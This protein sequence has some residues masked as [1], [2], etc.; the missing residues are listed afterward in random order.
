MAIKISKKRG[1][2]KEVLNDKKMITEDAKSFRLQFP[3]TLDE[4]YRA[5]LME[6][7]GARRLVDKIGFNP[8]GDIPEDQV[9]FLYVYTVPFSDENLVTLT[10][11]GKK[12]KFVFDSDIAVR[13]QALSDEGKT[14]AKMSEKLISNFD[15]IPKLG[16]KLLKFQPAAVEYLLRVKH[17]FLAD[18]MGLGK[19]VEALAGIAT[20]GRYPWLLCVPANQKYM[21]LET[22]QKWLKYR[23]VNGKKL[24]IQILRKSHMQLDKKG[25][26]SKASKA[27]FA[28]TQIIICNYEQLELSE[29][30]FT[31]VPWVGMVFD[32]SHYLKALNSQRSKAANRLIEATSPEYIW[33]LSGTPLLNKTVEMA[34]QLRVMQRLPDFGGFNNFYRRYCAI[35]IDASASKQVEAQL[36]AAKEAKERGEEVIDVSKLEQDDPLAAKAIQDELVR[37]AYAAQVDLHRN[38]R[39]TCYVRR[40][41]VDALPYLPPKTRTTIPLEITNRKVYQQIEKDVCGYLADQVAKDKKFIASLKKMSLEKQTAAIQERKD[42]RYYSAAKAEAL[43]RLSTLKLAAVAGKM[44]AA[45]QWIRDYL[46]SGKKLVVFAHHN[47]IIKEL[48]DEFPTAVHTRTGSLKKRAEAVKRF[49]EDDSVNLFIGSFMKDGVGHTLTA[50]NATAFLELGWNPGKHDQAE[51]RVYRIGQEA[52]AVFAYYLLANNTVEEK[53]AKLIEDKRQL[54]DAVADGDPLRSAHQGS[55]FA[56]ILD[57]LAGEE[58]ASN[59][60]AE[61]AAAKKAKT[62][63]KKVAKKTVTNVE[64]QEAA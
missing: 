37:K 48:I 27:F 28:E 17:T 47:I 49:Q 61:V 32:E 42:A 24:N 57:T 34:G 52:D 38:L 31:P 3:V 41:K 51:D 59:F 44:K 2:A 45:K 29:Q 33:E 8:K 50:A 15:E 40:E 6:I 21:W 20:V 55:I 1:R 14:L 43:V 22:A 46:D 10:R 4:E 16:G 35:S 12:H 39:S 56:S 36:R 53:I 13:A 19:T 60:A 30:F 9:E 23:K 5:E 11:F 58:E 63:K 26:V 7:S 25:K 18:D 54:V 62:K 64:Q